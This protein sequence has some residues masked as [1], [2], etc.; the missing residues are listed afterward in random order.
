MSDKVDELL[1]GMVRDGVISGYELRRSRQMVVVR[2]GQQTVLNMRILTQ[3]VA[4]DDAA[5]RLWVSTETE[6]HKPGETT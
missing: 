2:D 3:L 6:H 4:Q 5:A 1:D